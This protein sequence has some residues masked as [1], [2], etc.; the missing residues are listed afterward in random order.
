MVAEI[1]PIGRSASVAGFVLG[2]KL[3]SI[4]FSGYHVLILT[5]LAVVGFVEGYDLSLTSSLLVLAKAPLHLTESDIRWLVAGPPFMACV[6]GFAF[7]V[8][9]DHWSRKTVMQVGVIATTFLTLLIP[10][11]QNAEQLIILRLLT[12]LGAGG[13]VSA[14]FPIAAELMPAQHRRTYGATYEMAL[15]ASFTL[16]PF[17]SFLLAGSPNAFR[18]LA[19]PGGLVITVVPVLIHFAL[20]ES[21]RWYLRRGDAQAAADIVNQII[22]RG[23]DRVPLLTV[24]ALGDGPQTIREQLPP[25]WALFGRGQRRW[26][27]VGILSGVCAGTAALL[28]HTLLPK[29]MVDQGLAVASSFGLSTLVYLASI[30][31][32][33][34]TGFL[35]EIIGRRW[36]IA[37]ALAGSLPGLVLML[38]A[39]RAGEFAG[40][41]MV[42]GG[43]ITGFTVL[44]AFSA[45]RVYLS[46]QFPTSLRG[47]GQ[48]FGESFGRL[49]AGVLAPFLMVP[50]TGSPTIF[51]GTIVV[52]VS[53]G[54]FIP[55]IFG[56]ETVGQLETV[57]EGMPTL[58]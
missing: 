22:R 18:F 10:L 15:A 49:F 20:P 2:R 40:V 36:T 6:G 47:R 45:T 7:S 8:V 38:M 19:L 12:G 35:M 24:E 50:H 5:V 52:V 26:T 43:L 23:G 17:I 4:P 46:E 27:A 13:V 31:G 25:Y 28:I 9:A 34:F 56:K 57:T 21:P 58:A 42:A 51:F 33:A 14:A 53:V 39:H 29:A 55:L 1:R 37:Y 11:V 54:A 48:I 32:K 30:P 44:S 16:V 41:V 3:D